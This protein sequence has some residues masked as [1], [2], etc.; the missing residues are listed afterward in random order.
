MGSLFYLSAAF[1][2]IDLPL[3]NPNFTGVV[4]TGL[5]ASFF[6]LHFLSLTVIPSLCIFRFLFW[7]SVHL[8]SQCKDLK[9]ESPAIF[10]FLKFTSLMAFSTATRQLHQD[11]TLI[12]K[13]EHVY[14]LTHR[15][16][17]VKANSIITLTLR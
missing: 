16:F 17:K 3:L 13:I 8:L 14:N 11:V 5:N 12:S 1:D 2:H 15:A 10:C 4:I 6:Y 9:L 7:D